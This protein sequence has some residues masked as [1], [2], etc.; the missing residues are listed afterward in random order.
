MLSVSGAKVYFEDAFQNH[1]QALLGLSAL[2]DQ[3]SLVTGVL[4]AAKSASDKQRSSIAIAFLSKCVEAKAS[5][6]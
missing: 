6:S 3:P 4:V 1:L 5:P 2:H